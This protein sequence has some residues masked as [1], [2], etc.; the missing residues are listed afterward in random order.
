[1]IYNVASVMCDSTPISMVYGGNTS[2]VNLKLRAQRLCKSKP[3]TWRKVG[4]D[5]LCGDWTIGGALLYGYKQ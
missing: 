1:M 4:Y 5:T 3:I 2:V